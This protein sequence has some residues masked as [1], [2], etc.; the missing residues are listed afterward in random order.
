MFDIKCRAKRQCLN[1][2]SSGWNKFEE[3]K[4][5]VK[6]P[7]NHKCTIFIGTVRK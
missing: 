6:E 1:V 3:S 4:E 5:E 7:R 2:L